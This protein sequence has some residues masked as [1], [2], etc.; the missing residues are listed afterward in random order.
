MWSCYLT[1]G[2]W[3]DE[4]T[5]LKKTVGRLEHV[6]TLI[7]EEWLSA[8]AVGLAE[9]CAA[10]V[11]RQLELGADSVILHGATPAELSPIVAAYGMT[12]FG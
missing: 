6:A 5:R 1:V 9:H 8:A 3:L 10:M 4:P 12:P 7:P 2:D 11:Q